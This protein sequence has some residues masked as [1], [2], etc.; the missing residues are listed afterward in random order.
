VTN[1]SGQL[2]FHFF[3][4]FHYSSLC[5]LRYFS[6]FSNMLFDTL[7]LNFSIFP[8]CVCLSL[9]SLC[10]VVT[11]RLTHPESPHVSSYS[12]TAHHPHAVTPQF[13][14]ADHTSPNQQATASDLTCCPK[15][16]FSWRAQIGLWPL[17]EESSIGLFFFF[18][19]VTVKKDRSSW[20]SDVGCR[21]M[22]SS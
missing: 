1:I 16:V 10:Q 2:F 9:V 8:L 12:L 14:E 15:P 20:R 4:S 6:Y 7:S 11:E 22:K 13:V 18:W 19:A 3:L 21:V 17:E 5:Q